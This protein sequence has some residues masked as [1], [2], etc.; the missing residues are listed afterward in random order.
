MANERSRRELIESAK[1]RVALDKRRG[2]SIDQRILDWAEQ[3]P[4]DSTHQER[5]EQPRQEPA[6]PH[7]AET[8]SGVSALSAYLQRLRTALRTTPIRSTRVDLGIA[9][10]NSPLWVE[11]HY[12]HNIL[13]WVVERSRVL[14]GLHASPE[15]IR[16][17]DAIAG[18]EVAM[19][20]GDAPPQ[21][22]ADTQI[23]YVRL[24]KDPA[25]PDA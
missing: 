10:A 5:P 17:A 11:H 7:A 25:A 13:P 20:E 3:D 12:K 16:L 2:R 21:D 24:A 1:A 18:Y 15:E 6:T 8:S 14:P 19:A 23:I 9:A 4:N 22:E